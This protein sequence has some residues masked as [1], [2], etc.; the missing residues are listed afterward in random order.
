MSSPKKPIGRAMDATRGG[1]FASDADFAP[2]VGGTLVEATDVSLD[3]LFSADPDDDLGAKPRQRAGWK[4]WLAWRV[5]ISAG[6]AYGALRFAQASD[7]NI[8]Y[9]LLYAI[10]L[11]LFSVR[12]L[13]SSVQE[14]PIPKALRTVAPGSQLTSEVDGL[15]AATSRWDM[16]LD[17]IDRDPQRFAVRA[18]PLMIEIIDERLRQRH[19]FSLAS[20]P[21]RAR[22]VL[23]E[24]LWQ[25]LY[26]PITRAPTP[27]ELATMVDLMES[28]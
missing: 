23:G 13:L 16:R 2:P 21:H 7:L 6:L 1:R 17:W 27:K 14:T 15:A 12:R 28:V 22:K 8:P 26:A 18:R 24:T 19:G 20:D 11:A 25:S 5:A 9:P 4:V 10:F 3:E